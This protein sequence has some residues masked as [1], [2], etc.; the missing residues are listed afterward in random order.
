MLY[1]SRFHWFD[2]LFKSD[3]SLDAVLDRP[4]RGDTV[5]AVS[6]VGDD[7]CVAKCAEV[8]QVRNKFWRFADGRVSGATGS[9]WLGARRSGQ[10]RAR[11]ATGRYGSC[12]SSTTVRRAG[13]DPC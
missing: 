13:G 4:V 2:R 9:A 11:P 6:S 10:R 3:V 8:C 12:P 7:T 1:L 5:L